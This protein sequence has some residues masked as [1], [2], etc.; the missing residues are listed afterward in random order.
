MNA[1]PNALELSG[2]DV[3]PSLSDRSEVIAVRRKKFG[4]NRVKF[5]IYADDGMLFAVTR[6]CCLS[7]KSIITPSCLKRNNVVFDN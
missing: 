5:K 2:D 3:Q 4:K 7:I 6:L 1:R